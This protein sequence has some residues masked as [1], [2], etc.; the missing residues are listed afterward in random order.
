MSIILTSLNSDLIVRN[1]LRLE[2]SIESPS[3]HLQTISAVGPMAGG[4][5]GLTR[6]GLVEIK[7]NRSDFVG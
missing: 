6:S 3:V 2:P 4:H 5:P 1:E 7:L